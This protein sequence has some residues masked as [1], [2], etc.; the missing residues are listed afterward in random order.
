MINRKPI[1]HLGA[2][3]TPMLRTIS[4]GLQEAG[5][6]KMPVKDLPMRLRGASEV[7]GGVNTE[8]YTC[9]V[10][11]PPWSFRDH[12]PGPKRGASKYYDC[13]LSSQ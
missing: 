11:E 13:D 3:A 4:R 5:S 8:A 6:H 2:V 7:I 9:I 12:L 10:C 1:K